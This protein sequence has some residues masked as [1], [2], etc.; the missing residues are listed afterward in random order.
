[1]APAWSRRSTCQLS[2]ALAGFDWAAFARSFASLSPEEVTPVAGLHQARA[3]GF[4]SRAKLRGDVKLVMSDGGVLPSH[5][6]F[7]EPAS[8]L[9]H[10]ALAEQQR[11]G[12]SE[13]PRYHVPTASTNQVADLL[14]IVCALHGPK[15]LKRPLLRLKS[16]SLED[17]QGLV[18]AAQELQ[19][20]SVLQLAEQALIKRSECSSASQRS[21][22]TQRNVVAVSLWASSVGFRQLEEF[23]ALFIAAQRFCVRSSSW[24][25]TPLAGTLDQVLE[26]SHAKPGALQALNR[27]KR[28]A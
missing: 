14:G 28:A 25:D 20:A 5:T 8:S 11:E 24:P 17:V 15:P 12:R 6:S 26:Y 21:Y 2:V 23:C 22:V 7:L 9:L 18:H 27:L 13:V 16:L 1:M 3:E 19:C 4:L 10:E